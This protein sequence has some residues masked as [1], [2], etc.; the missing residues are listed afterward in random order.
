MEKPR[1]HRYLQGNPQTSMISGEDERESKK[2]SVLRK[3]GKVDLPFVKEKHM[4]TTTTTTMT[5]TQLTDGSARPT[6]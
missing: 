1:L 2:G 5:T 3:G 4:I 6:M